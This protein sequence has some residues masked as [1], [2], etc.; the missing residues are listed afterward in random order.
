MASLSL[1]YTGGQMPRKR[2]TKKR[3]CRNVILLAHL[4]FSWSISEEFQGKL[5]E[6]RFAERFV[7]WVNSAVYFGRLDTLNLQCN[8]VLQSRECLQ[9]ILSISHCVY[10][11][12]WP[13]STE[14]SATGTHGP[15]KGFWRGKQRSV[16]WQLLSS[17]VGWSSRQRCPVTAMVHLSTIEIRD[18]GRAS[19]RDQKKIE[20]FF[21]HVLLGHNRNRMGTS[22]CCKAQSWLL[23]ACTTEIH[24]V[25]PKKD[26]RMCVPGSSDPWCLFSLRLQLTTLIWRLD[27]TTVTKESEPGEIFP[28][29]QKTWSGWTP[30]SPSSSAP[31]QKTMVDHV[32]FV[33]LC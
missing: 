22:T 16:H 24:T 33:T 17:T 25:G 20:W 15:W 7:S 2:Y 8:L 1:V 5:G 13:G 9:L 30:T 6:V 23:S 27:V 10:S 18:D 11:R 12:R 28:E 3:M 26:K 14:F 4:H 21:F 31:R 19:W 32:L 29:R